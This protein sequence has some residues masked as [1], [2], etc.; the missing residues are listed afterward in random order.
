MKRVTIE[1]SVEGLSTPD[2]NDSVAIIRHVREPIV[3]EIAEAM[4]DALKGLG[5]DTASIKKGLEEAL[6]G[7]L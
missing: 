7:D 1:V 6:A 4:V 5:Y 3:S 2:T